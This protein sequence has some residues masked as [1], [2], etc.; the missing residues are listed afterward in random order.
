M[1]QSNGFGAGTDNQIVG[2]GGGYMAYPQP[3]V[4]ANG[5]GPEAD[6]QFGSLTFTYDSSTSAGKGNQF[7]IQNPG[8]N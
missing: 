1:W 5:V 2:G 3:Q 6:G 8:R 7:S 4:P